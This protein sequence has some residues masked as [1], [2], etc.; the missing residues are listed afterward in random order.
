MRWV[1]V[2]Q[3]SHIEAKVCGDLIELQIIGLDIKRISIVSQ[4]F[5]VITYLFFQ[6]DESLGFW[7]DAFN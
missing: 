6:Y 5:N 3:V 7:N 2:F 4:S 1:F